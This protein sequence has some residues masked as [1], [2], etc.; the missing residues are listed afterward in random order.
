[1]PKRFQFRLR[2][3]LLAVVPVAFV[4]LLIGWAMRRPRPI[5][6]NG[7]V[8]HDGQPLIGAQVTF[9]PID[10]IDPSGRVA[11]EL[12]DSTGG[13]Q[14]SSG[15]FPGSDGVAV[16]NWFSPRAPTGRVVPARYANNATSDL[17]AEVNNLTFNLTSVR[18]HTVT[19]KPHER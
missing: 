2:S 7:A 5:P 12:T 9:F 10:P 15:A 17:A 16:V 19:E 3:L 11:G 18:I 14:L 8:T 6:V 4:A 1:M 13:F